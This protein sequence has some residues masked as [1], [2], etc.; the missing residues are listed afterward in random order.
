[1]CIYNNQSHCGGKLQNKKDLLKVLQNSAQDNIISFLQRSDQSIDFSRVLRAFVASS[2]KLQLH[3]RLMRET[4]HF[5]LI[6]VSTHFINQKIQKFKVYESLPFCLLALTTILQRLTILFAIFIT[7]NPFLHYHQRK[8]N[9]RLWRHLKATFE[10]LRIS[11]RQQ[12]NEL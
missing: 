10:R 1:M 6:R 8:K 9:A 3:L 4:F 11:Q 5:C 12:E 2:A 7:F